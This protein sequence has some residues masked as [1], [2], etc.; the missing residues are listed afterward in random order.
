MN[1]AE[2]TKETKSKNNSAPVGACI[3][4]E[5][6][7]VGFTDV[8][9]A[10]RQRFRILAYSGQIIKNHW[11]WGNVAFDLNGAEFDKQKTGV[12]EEHNRSGRVGFTTM[13][14]ISDQIVVEGKFLSSEP[15]QKMRKDM[16]E[17][18]PMQ[19]SVYIVPRVIERIEQGAST[20][21][22]GQKLDG[23]G[24]VF[25]KSTIFEVSLCCLGADNN[26]SGEVF[27]KNENV[28]F[29]IFERT[30]NMSE[31]KAKL[32]AETFAKD[33]PELFAEIQTA[34][35][36]EGRVEGKK[37][38]AAHVV[39]FCERFGK[40]PAFVLE[41]LTKGSSL[42]DATAAYSAKLEKENAELKMAAA[43]PHDSA[44][45]EINTGGTSPGSRATDPAIQ[46]FA[47]DASAKNNQG[48]K[49]ADTEEGW[50]VEFEKSKDLQAEFDGKV[51]DYVAYKKAKMNRQ[52]RD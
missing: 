21:V 34:A 42:E 36:T 17:G 19:A 26:T 1:M 6:T 22:N 4:R 37:E 38:M 50:R 45:S 39:K 7:I 10:D 24:T 35:K 9:N 28:N 5:T 29:D 33:E 25:R 14:N 15:A 52:V 3:F 13:Q 32:T 31:Q 44:K 23:P 18:F 48:K 46:A 43:S 51:E 16:D 41:Q 49:P 40:D 30:E 11:Y 8:D 2:M 12:L 20:M 47:D 27:D